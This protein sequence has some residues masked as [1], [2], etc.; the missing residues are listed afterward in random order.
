MPK[1]K[2]TDTI[3]YVLVSTLSTQDNVKLL[4]KIESGFK[5]TV[6]WNKYQSKITSQVQNRYLDFLIDPN[7]QEVDILFV[8]SFENEEDG[9]SDKKYYLPIIEIKNVIINRRIFFDQTAKN[10]LRRYDHIRKIATGQGDNYT[11]GCLL[12]YPF[13]KEYYKLIATDLYKQ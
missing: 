9:E 1:L 8:L 10:N 11:T 3:L 6:N 7:F 12:D 4:K 13:F 5:R 2:I